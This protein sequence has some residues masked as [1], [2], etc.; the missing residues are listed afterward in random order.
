MHTTFILILE[1]ELWW[2]DFDDYNLIVEVMIINCQWGP[3]VWLHGVARELNAWIVLI[4]AICNTN[5]IISY[6]TDTWIYYL[7][8]Q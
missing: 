1:G 2:A 7:V 4:F 3:H 5:D 6:V 8:N